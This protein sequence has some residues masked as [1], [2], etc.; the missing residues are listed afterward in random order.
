ML[1][2]KNLTL[3][4]TK[5]L[6]TLLEDFSFSLQPDM[7]VALVG[8]EGNGKSTLLKTISE[9]ESIQ[10]YLEIEGEII[11]AG[12]IVGYL[13][14]V[15]ADA[16]L[17]QTTA[18]FF[19][20]KVDWNHFDYGYYY[21]L[22]GEMDFPED[23][24]SPKINFGDLSGGEKIKLQL[25]CEMLKG[26]TVLLLDEPSNDLDLESVRWLEGFIRTA[27]IPIMF[28]SHDELLL[29]R[30]ANTI[31]HLEQLMRKQRPQYTVARLGYGEY[32]KNRNQ[33]ILRQTRLA[34]KEKVEYEAKM[35][36]YRQ[37][38][39]RVHHEQQKVS[40]QA[41]SVAKNLKDKMHAVKSM[42][43]RFEREKEGMTK[44]PDFEQSIDISFESGITI[45]QGKVVLDL[46]LN[47]LQVEGLI[48][49]RNINLHVV[50]PEKICIVGSNGAGKTTLLKEILAELEARGTN[51][52]YMPQDYSER[53][54]PKENA[55]Q[56]LLNSSTKEEY[57][58]VRTYLGSMNFTADEM[59]HPIVELS[60]GQRAKLYFSKMILDNAK[61]LVLDE[62]TRNLSPLSG[63]EV[64][65]ALKDF[66]G[67]IIAVSHDRKFISEVFEKVLHLDVNGLHELAGR[68]DNSPQIS[69]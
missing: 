2:I 12:E 20:N 53:M 56:F 3:T 32:V 50:G 28:V 44:R 33:S 67:C 62:P 61:V 40:R 42:G 9:P 23:R 41:P 7:K 18:H 65:A 38:F 58:K 11:T 35:D 6:R 46:S 54:N 51:F 14:Q 22:L 36:R 13:P 43:R 17:D 69:G 55:I 37:I 59:H 34:Q 64:R 49:S 47:T 4:L 1:V 19:D 48:L 27:K 66:G 24:I 8:E 15:I 31:I 60:G 25:L 52:G 29:E 5:D 39:Q 16:T 68:L 26:P 30:C 45:P 63:P 21:Q 57:T 10:S